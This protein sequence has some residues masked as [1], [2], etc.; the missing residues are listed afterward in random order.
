MRR[1]GADEGAGGD[2]WRRK[3][4]LWG[5]KGWLCSSL[6]GNC[7]RSQWRDA[8]DGATGWAQ[9]CKCA[10]EGAF[11]VVWVGGLG[12]TDGVRDA[13]TLEGSARRAGPRSV[14]RGVEQQR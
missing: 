3:G 2:A 8:G 10:R 6:R 11:V 7:G 14:K 9:G 13:V 4:A 5:L 12:A 1:A